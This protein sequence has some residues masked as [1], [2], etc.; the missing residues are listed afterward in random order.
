M[1]DSIDKFDDINS[2]SLS[3][4]KYRVV[5][6]FKPVRVKSLPVPA[7]AAAAQHNYWTPT[8]H[9]N[10][11]HCCQE[12]QNMVVAVAMMEVLPDQIFCETVQWWC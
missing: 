5:K 4:D 1:T 7:E 6:C 10:I 8:A 12:I 3:S 2:I 9:F 11:V